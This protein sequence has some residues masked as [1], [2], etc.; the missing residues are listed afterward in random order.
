MIQ[1]RQI[2]RPRSRG[3]HERCARRLAVVLVSAVAGS[4]TAP[5]P[6]SSKPAAS[7]LS[8]DD[9][10]ERVVRS[11][12]PGRVGDILLVTERSEVVT[13]PDEAHRFMHG[14]PWDYDARVP[15]ILYGPAYVEAG[16]YGG[17]PSHQDMGATLEKLLGL[18]P[19]PT[20]TGQAVGVLR[21]EAEAPL[22]V[23]VLVLDALRPD[24]FDRYA[25]RFPALGRLR[26]EGASFSEAAANYV[27]T[28][29]SVS[30]TTLVT[31]TD[32]RVHGVTG[33]TLY[34]REAQAP[35]SA[36][37]GASAHNVMVPTLADRWAR[38]TEGQSV[39]AT[40]GGTDYPAVA[41]AGHGRC[42][43][44]GRAVLVGFYRS[45]EGRW[46][47]NDRC[48]ALPAALNGRSIQALLS[49]SGGRWRGHDVSDPSEFRR[50]ALFT[51]F[52][53]EAAAATLRSEPFGA[54]SVTDLFFANLKSTDYVSHKYGPFS[55]EMLETLEELD[56]QV[57]DILSALEEVAG[58]DGYV[59]LVTADHGMSPE[60][61]GERR[62]RTYAEVR[63]QVNE[64]FDPDG[65]GLV[66][67]FEGSE[68][69]MYLDQERLQGLGLEVADVAEFLESLPW[70]AAAITE[71]DLASSAVG[72]PTSAR[73]A[74]TPGS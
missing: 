15:F 7:D 21:P 52:E 64:R 57:G 39:I 66:L 33:N 3:G 20:S 9:L 2:P 42:Q 72:R 60:P 37:E 61:T 44:G 51:R 32:P 14:S 59:V 46:G 54:D 24:Y 65:P 48:Y 4:C 40:Q 11:A 18:A 36:F 19:L 13:Y 12:Y 68:N 63:A 73:G 26:S 70:V 69:Y 58:P 62:R 31:A 43:G 5:A 10:V 71:A 49:E 25:D 17:S 41:L 16:V 56:R 38:L 29:T 6:E 74:G 28:S 22:V 34:D 35:E 45:G 50:S 8:R 47:T 23:A 67:H 53:G 55:S 27:P 30:H 1:W